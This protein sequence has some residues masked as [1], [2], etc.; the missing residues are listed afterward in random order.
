MMR[1]T[2][3][4]RIVGAVLGLV[5]SAVLAGCGS[6]SQ[7]S[8]NPGSGGSSGGAG[9]PS[10]SA[11]E[12]G[13]PYV[14]QTASSTPAPELGFAA[15]AA[16]KW[17]NAHGGI[18]GRPLQ[19]DKC[20]DHFTS[21][22]SAA[23]MRQ[24]ADNK[25]VMGLAGGDVC[26]TDVSDALLK[27]S[28]LPWLAPSGCGANS[29][30]G[31][32][33]TLLGG[34]VVADARALGSL[35]AQD[36]TPAEII[37]FN[38]PQADVIVNSITDSAKAGGGTILGAVRVDPATA[39]MTAAVA[40]ALKHHPQAIIPQTSTAQI[41]STVQALKQQGFTGKIILAASQVP[42][43]TLASLGSASKQ[44][45]GAMAEAPV[46]APAAN[47]PAITEF[48]SEMKA[49]GASNAQ[50]TSAAFQTW[51]AYHEFYDAAAKAKS[52]TRAGI[53]AAA[54]GLTNW[55]YGRANPP[56]TF[57]APGSFKGYPNIVMHWAAFLTVQHNQW[58]WDG[59]WTD[60]A[61]SGG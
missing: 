18:K 58:V 34:G 40:S 50:M 13:T 30:T 59:K 16:V 32:E 15:D 45:V 5:A 36:K 25:N 44:I 51:L 26:F 41:A 11:I 42:A 6:S 2:K 53:L 19:V 54:K 31:S 33:F 24:Y 38:L 4:A 56:M 46:P 39:D 9:A 27:S 48:R 43:A 3:Y 35:I 47:L 37:T 52:L 55:Q 23:C 61:V 28:G 57:S 1:Y 10:G 49:V 20:D 60:L 8:S 22:G 7:S 29:Y 21:A 17:I 14:I 12:V